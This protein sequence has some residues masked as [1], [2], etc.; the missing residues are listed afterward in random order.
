M[1]SHTRSVRIPMNPQP[2]QASNNEVTSMLENYSELPVNQQDRSYHP[3]FVRK[4]SIRVKV[5]MMNGLC[6]IGNCHVLWPDGRT[7]DVLNDQRAFLILTNATVEGEHN[8]YDILTL[9]KSRIEMIFELHGPR[10]SHRNR[11]TT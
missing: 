4:K 5:Q 7:S 9:N 10:R 1:N 8:E 2:H 3:D 11:S 6:C